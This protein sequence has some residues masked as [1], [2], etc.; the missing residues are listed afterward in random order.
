MKTFSC[1]YV[2]FKHENTKTCKF[3][4]K[5]SAYSYHPLHHNDKGSITVFERVSLGSEGLP[6]Q[7]I[8]HDVEEG[9]H[10]VVSL[11]AIPR[12]RC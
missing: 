11:Q 7:C 8:V 4:C 5:F 2:N 9:G 10:G 12:L 1:F 6:K 3:L